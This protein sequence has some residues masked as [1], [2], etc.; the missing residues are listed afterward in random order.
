LHTSRRRRGK[1]KIAREAPQ[2]QQTR[3]WDMSEFLRE[4]SSFGT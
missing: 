3:D 4:D 1:L 2:R